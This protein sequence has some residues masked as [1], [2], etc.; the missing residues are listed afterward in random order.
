MQGWNALPL[1]GLDGIIFVSP[2]TQIVRGN[3]RTPTFLVHGT[4]DDLIPWQQSKG[5]YNALVDQGVAAGL[6][7]VEGAPHTCDLSSDSASEG[8][9]AAL[10]GY[11]FL[12]S[13]V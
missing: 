9:K 1:P 11:D 3:Y 8:W 4:K 13:F 12:D 10:K 6:A 5:T 2:L 7:L